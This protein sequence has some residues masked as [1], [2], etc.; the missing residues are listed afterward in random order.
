MKNYIYWLISVLLIIITVSTFLLTVVNVIPPILLLEIFFCMLLLFIANTSSGITCG[1]IQK[2]KRGYL[3][4]FAL[5]NAA[6]IA[7]LIYYIA[8]MS[9]I[10]F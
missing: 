5:L 10:I 3:V 7:L 4:G 6:C 8:I 9:I 2:G 1:I